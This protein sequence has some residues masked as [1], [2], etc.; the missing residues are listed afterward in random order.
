[1]ILQ[2]CQKIRYFLSQKKCPKKGVHFWAQKWTP[3]LTPLF[4]CSFR[5]MGPKIENHVG[6][7]P[8]FW[9]KRE[10]PVFL[11]PDL[12]WCFFQ[13]IHFDQKNPEFS[14]F[15]HFWVQKNRKKTGFLS[16]SCHGF[17]IEYGCISLW[18]KRVKKEV[19]KGHFGPFL[20]G[21]GVI[22]RLPHCE[23]QS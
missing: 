8:W 16:I 11:Y 7:Y 5:A 22:L 6:T 1:M 3:F 21:L 10:K 19:K 9:S 13:K 4:L 18:N 14:L 20:R 23:L 17:S 12:I 15:E 2:N